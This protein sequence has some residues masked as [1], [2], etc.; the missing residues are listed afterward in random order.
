VKRAFLLVF[1]F[2]PIL[3]T[4]CGQ[5]LLGF[6]ID[7]LVLIKKGSVINPGSHNSCEVTADTKAHVTFVEMRS[8]GSSHHEQKL[9]VVSLEGTG[10]PCK[11]GELHK[12]YIYGSRVHIYNP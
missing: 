9:T 8:E 11:D 12:G 7:S 1:V 10:F 4:A 6:E 5:P 2:V 3:L